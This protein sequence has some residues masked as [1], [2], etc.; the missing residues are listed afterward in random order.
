VSLCYLSPKWTHFSVC[1]AF[2][3]PRGCKTRMSTNRCNQLWHNNRNSNGETTTETKTTKSAAHSF[4]HLIFFRL[5]LYTF[6]FLSCIFRSR[7]QLILS[8]LFSLYL[9]FLPHA[10]WSDLRSM[11]VYADLKSVFNDTR[12]FYILLFTIIRAMGFRM[13]VNEK[14]FKCNKATSMRNLWS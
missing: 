9:S 4:R 8:L 11:F 12:I 13:R 14:E 2:D 10:P 5:H 1:S 3:D 6:F 7:A